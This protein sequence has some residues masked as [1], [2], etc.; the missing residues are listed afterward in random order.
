MAISRV[1]NARNKP[2]SIVREK[3]CQRLDHVWRGS[4]ST[5]KHLTPALNG[6]T[7]V[8]RQP[9]QVAPARLGP[10]EQ[11]T[12]CPAQRPLWP[13]VFT[14]REACLLIQ[15]QDHA[16]FDCR[17]HIPKK[18]QSV[19]LS[20]L[21]QFIRYDHTRPSFASANSVTNGNTKKGAYCYKAEISLH[22]YVYCISDVA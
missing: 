13:F 8:F 10:R 11:S 19:N 17:G 16:V 22:T 6:N 15:E 1:C 4:L 3:T 7:S 18:S 12:E 20:R 14:W 9:F 5:M 21:D 2:K